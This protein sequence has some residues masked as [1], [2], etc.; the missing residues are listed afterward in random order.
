MGKSRDLIYPPPAPLLLNTIEQQEIRPWPGNHLNNTVRERKSRHLLGRPS[1][2]SRGRYQISRFCWDINNDSPKAYY[3]I[4]PRNWNSFTSL[5]QQQI[6]RRF[7]CKHVASDEENQVHFHSVLNA[8]SALLCNSIMQISS[9]QPRSVAK[10]AEATSAMEPRS[11]Q[12]T[13]LERRLKGFRY[14]FND[15]LLH[16]STLENLGIETWELITP[17]DTWSYSTCQVKTACKQESGVAPILTTTAQRHRLPKRRH[18]QLLNRS[19][20]TAALGRLPNELIIQIMRQLD[21]CT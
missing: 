11:I 13:R 16:Q 2:K 1:F 12:K 4:I 7:H 10:Q 5:H 17:A 19:E 20:Q 18:R 14:A 8:I 21:R 3:K 15:R 9:L 6:S